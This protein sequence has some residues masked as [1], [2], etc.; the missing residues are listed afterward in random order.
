MPKLLLDS[1]GRNG[2]T[3][4]FISRSSTVPEAQEA[5]TLFGRGQ[6]KIRVARLDEAQ[7][8][9]DLT[10]TLFSGGEHYS[11]ISFSSRSDVEQLMSQG[12]FILAENDTAIVGYA[13]LQLCMEA[14]RL[15]FLAVSPQQQRTGIGSQLLEAV[16]RLSGSMR[17]LFMHI[18]VVNLNWETLKFCRRRGYVAF[19]IA[20]LHR[21]QTVSPH[22]HIVRMCK[23]LDNDGSEF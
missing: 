8:I 13:Y 21:Q 5:Q 18:Q 20:P 9:V 16:E 11:R 3:E 22:C 12:K 23:Q 6:L 14:S 10:N 1:N 4:R 7:A 19:A 17:C 2:V 15:E